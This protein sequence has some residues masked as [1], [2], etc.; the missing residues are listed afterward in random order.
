MEFDESLLEDATFE[1]VT[2]AER[3]GGFGTPEPDEAG[4]ADEH[5]YLGRLPETFERLGYCLGFDIALIE[6]LAAQVS[7]LCN[8]VANLRQEVSELRG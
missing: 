7:D 4:P 6:R 1:R 2:R 3:L 8:E 5:A